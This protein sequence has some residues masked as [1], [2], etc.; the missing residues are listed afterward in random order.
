MDKATSV[1]A[2]LDAGKIPD[3]K[4]VATVIDWLLTTGI[5]EVEPSGSAQLSQQGRAIA[6]GLREVLKAYKQLGE[7]K[8]SKYY[9]SS[10]R[11]R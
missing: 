2:A 4:Q 6:D 7:S 5:P 9:L 3:H 10:Q 11:R 1:L 8:N